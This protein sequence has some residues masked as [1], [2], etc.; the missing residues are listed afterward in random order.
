MTDILNNIS[1]ILVKPTL[2]GLSFPDGVLVMSGVYIPWASVHDDVIVEVRRLI[3][4]YP[5]YILE[6]TGHS[7][8]GSLTYLS[9]IALAQNFPGKS[10][11]SNA[12][13]TFPIGNAAFANFGQ[14][15]SGLLRR[16]NN[17]ADGVPVSDRLS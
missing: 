17:V 6:S 4:L 5:T 14:S 9:Y 10:L 12:L 16:G 1:T 3:G 15:Q 11:V 2:S 8:G 13:A 7:L